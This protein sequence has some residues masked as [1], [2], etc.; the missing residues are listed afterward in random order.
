MK[1]KIDDINGNIVKQDDRY[2]VKDNTHLKNLVVSSTKLNRNKEN[3]IEGYDDAKPEKVEKF[4]RSVRKNKVSEKFVKESFDTLPPAL[5]KYLK[6]AGQAGKKVG[7]KHFLGYQ[8]NDGTT[9]SNINDSDIKLENGKPIPVRGKIPSPDR[10]LLVWRIYL[11]QGGVCAYTGLPLDLESMD[12]EHVV[13]I[14]NKDKGDPKDH[15]LERENERNHVLTTSRMNQRKKDKN[16]NEFFE[17]EVDILNDKTEEDFKAMERGIEKVNTMQPRTEQT[18]LRMMDEVKFRI[19]GGKPISQSELLE[20]PE[21]DRPEITTTD[22]GTPKVVEANFGPNVTKET[23]Q[24]EFDFEE[25]EFSN[26]RT[27]LK[28]QLPD[29]EKKKA[30]S[31]KTKIGKRTLNALGL[32]GNL[33]G[34]DRRTNSISS[35]NFYKG[36]CLAVVSVPPEKREE[37]K[38]VWQ[39]ARKFANERDENGKLLNDK[40]YGKN[41]KN[42]FVKFIREKGLIPDEILN[43]KR[44]GKVWRYK[45]DN[46]EVV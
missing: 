27:V 25:M 24:K 14:Q 7:D 1:F 13:G 5:K 8:R 30:D 17:D 44:Y 43:D 33:E 11:E 38:K 32:P 16:M 28:E 6:G 10:A 35:D 36:Y 9:T 18:A 20:I 40:T 29:R 26:T 45:N 46:G 21:D 15:I 37:Y 19:K 3:L 41:Q 39:E 22:L 23:L 42:E 4:V 12:L 31:I 2:I 34:E